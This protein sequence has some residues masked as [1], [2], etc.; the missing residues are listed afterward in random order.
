MSFHCQ[1]SRSLSRQALLAGYLSAWLKRCV[2]P[3]PPYD[4][5]ASLTVS[6]CSVSAQTL[7]GPTTRYGVPYSSGLRMLTEQFCRRTIINWSG[8]ELIFPRDRPSPRVEMPHAYLVVW[9]A[10]HSPV[11]I[12]PGE[13]PPEGEYHTHLR[14]FENSQWVGRYLV[15][16]RRLVER[17]YSYCL[18]RYF[19][20]IPDITYGKEFRDVEDKHTMLG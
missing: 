7:A 6:S 15:G 4:G 5:I 17:Q 13:E 10:V 18:F 3:S 16:V 1:A 14:R 20:H 19:P 2:V 12:Q 9:F 11:F 8:K